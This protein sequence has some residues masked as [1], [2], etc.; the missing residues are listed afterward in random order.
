MAKFL[1]GGESALSN[2]P[3]PDAPLFGQ[4]CVTAPGAPF[5]PRPGKADNLIFFAEL[6]TI[7]ERDRAEA[8]RI[9]DIGKAQGMNHVPWAGIVSN[10]YGGAYPATN[11]VGQA[12]QIADY[13]EW[14]VANGVEFSF[15]AFTDQAPYYD[16]DARRF[17]WALIRR[18]FVPIFK[19]PRIQAIVR[20]VIYMWE[21]Y[22]DSRHMKEGW[23]ILRE[24]FE[25]QERTWHNPPGHP[26]PGE[27]YEQER[28]LWTYA[29]TECGCT[30]FSF[31]GFAMDRREDVAAVVDHVRIEMDVDV[32]RT[33]L[34]QNVY[35]AKDL[36]RSLLHGYGGVP[37]E[38][39]DG[40]PVTFDAT[41]LT[42]H[43]TWYGLPPSLSRNVYLTMR[44]IPGVRHILD[45]LPN[46]E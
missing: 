5:G 22:Q 37:T 4:F 28:P 3:A 36:I 42:A 24:C 7:W 27:S 34:E 38:T 14:L 32:K 1:D 44:A 10:G 6:M 46:A 33:P 31:Q 17:D 45:A 20:K 39:P 35:D 19:H 16:S 23:D 15:F 25:T 30:G 21:G 18:D 41:E 43:G 26:N 8:Q 12:D 11:R 2:R 40:R 29:I 9:L 13:L